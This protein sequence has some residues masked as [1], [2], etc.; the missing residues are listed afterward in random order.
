MG[1]LDFGAK[2]TRSPNEDALRDADCANEMR[3]KIK[4]AQGGDARRLS[5]GPDGAELSD[6]K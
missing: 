3:L 6:A 4:L 2:S 5:Q 1:G